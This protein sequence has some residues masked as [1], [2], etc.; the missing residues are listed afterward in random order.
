MAVTTS[1]GERTGFWVLTATILASSMAFIDGSAL[2]VALPAL[3]E[4]LRA[5]GADL[6]WINNAYGLMLAALILVGGALGDLYGRKRIFMVGI[7]LFAVASLLCGLA[8]NSGTLIAARTLQGLGGSLM[9][10]GSLA[11]IAA[12]FSEGQRGAAIGV[13]GSLG[14]GLL[15]P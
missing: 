9:I 5:S 2:H 1:V 6:L 12:N 7:G 15:C 8:P 13:G 11:L 10:P 3:Q 4:D 14:A